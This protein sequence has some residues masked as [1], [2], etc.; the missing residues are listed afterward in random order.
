[1]SNGLITGAQGLPG[2]FHV[3]EFPVDGGP[4]VMVPTSP[5]LTASSA[6]MPGKILRGANPDY[7]PVLRPTNSNSSSTPRPQSRS[8]FR[9]PNPC[10][11]QLM[12]GMM[13][14]VDAVD[15]SSTGTRVKE[16]APF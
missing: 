10:S 16:W 14:A 9:C 8:V 3:R 1:V 15:G 5:I 7:L 13:S 6:F 2:I 12:T 4:S 11:L